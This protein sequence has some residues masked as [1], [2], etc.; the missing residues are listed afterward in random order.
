MIWLIL[1][2]ILTNQNL[3]CR[4]LCPLQNQQH[5][6][7]YLLSHPK[8]IM[9]ITTSK[10]SKIH[11]ATAASHK[12]QILQSN[13]QLLTQHRQSAQ[14]TAVLAAVHT[15]AAAVPCWGHMGHMT[16]PVSA[17]TAALTAGAISAAALPTAQAAMHVT[18]LSASAAKVTVLTSAW[19]GAL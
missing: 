2:I 12:Q 10:L 18:A 19:V 3:H 5:S 11:M 1:R 17:N 15:A 14:K 13:F 8:M 4:S 7:S 9:S 16:I 6:S